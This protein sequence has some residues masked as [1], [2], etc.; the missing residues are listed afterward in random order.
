[1]SRV[2]RERA[3]DVGIRGGRGG[4]VV[5]IQ[6]FGGGLNLNV[7]FHALMLDGVFA[8]GPDGVE[9]FS[10]TPGLTTLDV[11]DVLATVEPLVARH[12]ARRGLGVDDAEAGAI[13]PWA[14][15]APGLVDLAA[16]SV[17][18]ALARGSRAHAWPARS[19]MARGAAEPPTTRLCQA[20]AN[21]FS[22]H[23]G[24]VVP[25]GRRDRL[26]R[27]CRYVLRP[28]VAA[29]RLELTAD[30]QV[31][32]SLRHPWRDGTTALVFD[33]VSFLGRLAVLVPRPR[34]NLVLYYG[35]LGARS[36]W[37]AA[38]VPRA[39]SE[40]GDV[41]EASGREATAGPEQ[42]AASRAGRGSEWAALMARTFGLDVLAC[43]RCGGRLRLVALIEQAAVIKRML[44]HLRLPTEIPP[45]R[46]ARAPPDELG[47]PGAG[48]RVGDPADFTPCS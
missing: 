8:P 37:R 36:A 41:A 21:G 38:V 33:P 14:D 10:R 30:G 13:D 24:L 46:P 11:M 45:P 25:G 9:A 42:G 4:G 43:P 2:L 48:D 22:L 12:L 26:E 47:W 1:V 29:E 7:H 3:R 17:R 39:P 20:E 34:V 15:E 6:R 18:G 32:L 23:A 35:V 40:Q 44:G 27:V 16:A 31:R 5:V 28:P 19:G